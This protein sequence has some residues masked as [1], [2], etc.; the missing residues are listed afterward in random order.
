LIAEVNFV[1]NDL[2]FTPGGDSILTRDK[3]E[4]RWIGVLLRDSSTQEMEYTFPP[5]ISR[6]VA[7]GPVVDSVVKHGPAFRAGIRP[8][9][10]ILEVDGAQSNSADGF[11]KTLQ[12]RSVGEMVSLLIDRDGDQILIKV[13]IGS[14]NFGA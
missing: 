10:K 3:N 11:S 12:S 5:K 13:E 6:P 2:D 7:V 8:G 14:K 9:D 1:N 4:R